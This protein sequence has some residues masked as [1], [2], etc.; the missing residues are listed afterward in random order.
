VEKSL[1]LG[2]KEKREKRKEKRRRKEEGER[3]KKKRGHGILY[4][5]RIELY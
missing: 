3:R 2:L 4:I 1:R 5:I